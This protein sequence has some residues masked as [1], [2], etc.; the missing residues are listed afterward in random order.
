[1]ASALAGACD[2]DVLPFETASA[3]RSASLGLFHG[4][5]DDATDEVTLED[6]VRTTT[7]NEVMSRPAMRAG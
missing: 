7:G 6:Q 4:A 1:M 3:Q 5:R 2:D